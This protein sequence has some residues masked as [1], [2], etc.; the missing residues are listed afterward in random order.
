LPKSSFLTSTIYNILGRI[1]TKL[2]N[3]EKRS[4]TYK[5]TWN[6]QNI[7]SGV[8]FFKV[9]AGEYSKV[10]KMMLLK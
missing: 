1:I 4:G 3:E 5:I 8:Y 10:K 6:A 7:S 9:T 2:G